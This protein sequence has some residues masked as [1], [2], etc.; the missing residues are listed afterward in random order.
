M[1]GVEKAL[2]EPRAE[3]SF[4]TSGDNLYLM[5]KGE[6]TVVACPLADRL[7]ADYLASNVP[8][9]GVTLDLSSAKWVDSRIPV[10]GLLRA[11]VLIRQGQCDQTVHVALPVP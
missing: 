10:P 9:A 1:R 7:V 4:G 11:P 6:A 8:S 2:T 3:I 5:V